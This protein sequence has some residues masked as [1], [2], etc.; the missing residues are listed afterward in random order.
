MALQAQP[1]TE[2]EEKGSLAQETAIRPI[3]DVN[4]SK[5]R[6]QQPSHEVRR[7]A[8]VQRS[9]PWLYVGPVLSGKSGRLSET[10]ACPSPH[11]EPPAWVE[12]ILQASPRS[13]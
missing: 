5:E 6:T 1:N 8:K 9:P 4:L 10:Q 13:A 2:K 7:K 3:H 11:R 12:I